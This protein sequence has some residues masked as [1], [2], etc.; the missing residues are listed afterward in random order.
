MRYALLGAI[1]GAIAALL[2]FLATPAH[3]VQV[4][5]LRLNCGGTWYDAG[6]TISERVCREGLF[7]HAI[8]SGFPVDT[9]PVIR[10]AL[11]LN[12]T[13]VASE[14]RTLPAHLGPVFGEDWHEYSGL[15]LGWH[16]PLDALCHPGCSAQAVASLAIVN[17]LDPEVPFT[18]DVP[19]PEPASIALLGASL[20]LL[21][22]RLRRVR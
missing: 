18:L 22:W 1:A 10:W 6:A 4:T 12:G 19:T 9:D 17:G 3:A 2:L 11:A 21:G 16:L 7:L 15:I 14:T 8:V 5:S 13:E 20:V